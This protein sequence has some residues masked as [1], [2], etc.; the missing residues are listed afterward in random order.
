MTIAAGAGFIKTWA[1]RIASPGTTAGE[2][3]RSAGPLPGLGSAR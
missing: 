1:G 2:I 3:V